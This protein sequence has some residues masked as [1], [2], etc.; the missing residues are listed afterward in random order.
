MHEYQGPWAAADLYRA[1]RAYFAAVMLHDALPTGN[2]NGH[3]R[4]LIAQR[5]DFGI[6][7]DDVQFLAYWDETG[8]KAQGDDIKLAGWQR[9]GKL[10]LLVANFGKAQPAQ[11]ET[12]AWQ[13]GLEG[14][15]PGREGPRAGAR[16]NRLWPW[17]C[18]H[19]HPRRPGTAAQRRDS[20]RTG[21]A[22]QL[23]A[24]DH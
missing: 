2:H 5:R 7:E 21:Q 18:R 17:R 24:A 14:G 10:L 11:V 20:D 23:S 15:E 4:N 9:P 12:R 19:R 3:A 22:P 13:A 16:A 6:G 8:L 1:K